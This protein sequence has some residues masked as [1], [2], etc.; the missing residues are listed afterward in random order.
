[1]DD[2]KK[3]EF[4]RRIS[5]SNRSELIV[6]IYDIFFAYAQ[7][8]REAL[9]NGNHD[10][11]LHALRKAQEAVTQ[12]RDA[13]DFQ[14]DISKELYS[15]YQYAL[16]QIATCFYR[17][18]TKGLDEAEGIL[19]R[20]RGSFAEVAKQDQSEPLMEH[21]QQVVA[22]MTYQMGN[23]T[24]TLQDSESSRGFLA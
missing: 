15:L 2:N 20:L 6:V 13:L 4:T 22:G 10:D 5:N 1:M 12:L 14:Y 24:E 23:L 7:D 9:E 16:E 11:Y 8:A 19:R 3:Q 21:A 18:D 17:K